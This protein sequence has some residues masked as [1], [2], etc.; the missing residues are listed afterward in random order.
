MLH[1]MCNNRGREYNAAAST[2][3]FN[4]HFCVHVIKPNEGSHTHT[5]Q[6]DMPER[7]GGWEK[8]NNDIIIA[9][10]AFTAIKGKGKMITYCTECS[11]RNQ[12]RC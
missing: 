3:R 4:L 12:I 9:I 8:C 2:E 6:Q 10:K 7:R 11:R 1:V 5:L